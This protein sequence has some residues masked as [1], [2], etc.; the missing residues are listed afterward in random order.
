TSL[1]A[2]EEGRLAVQE[3]IQVTRSLNQSET[4]IVQL[5]AKL[6]SSRK[7]ALQIESDNAALRHAMQQT[8]DRIKTFSSDEN[9]VDRRI[10]NKLLV[11]Y[12]ER[13]ASA[14]VINLMIKMLGFTE[15]QKRL[16]LES[17]RL[18]DVLSMSSKLNNFLFG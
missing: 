10:V 9:L 5:E 18:N 4:A 14:E 17:Q 3:L 12:L 1:D 16:V 15:E 11:T 8:M 2:A 7:Y 13:K 6:S